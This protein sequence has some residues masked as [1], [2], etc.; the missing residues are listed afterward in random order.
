MDS[1]L[2]EHYC[3]FCLRIFLLILRVAEYHKIDT[4]LKK[5]L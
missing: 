4:D 1:Y 3:H 5:C 2:I